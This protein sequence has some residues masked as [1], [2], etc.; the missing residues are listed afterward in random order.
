M[1]ESENVSENVSEP[2]AAHVNVRLG[3]TPRDTAVYIDGRLVPD[4]YSLAMYASAADVS[5]ARLVLNRVMPPGQSAP[6]RDGRASVAARVGKLLAFSSE[7]YAPPR[8]TIDVSGVV[9]LIEEAAR[10][11]LADTP[12]RDLAAV[13]AFLVQLSDNPHAVQLA[14]VIRDAERYRALRA[15]CDDDERPSAKGNIG[16]VLV[17][18]YSLTSAMLDE[19]ADRLRDEAAQANEEP[20][21]P[22]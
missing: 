14:D 9:R 10:D 13:H 17:D 21:R 16:F 4:V 20:R 7:E 1:T 15:W 22:T 5:P 6:G 8:D 2:R 11:S 19:H 3:E 18:D 12:V